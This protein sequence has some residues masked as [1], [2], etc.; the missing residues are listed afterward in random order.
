MASDRIT[1]FFEPKGDKALVKAINSLARAQ[2]R[3][4]TTS[5][6]VT[7]GNMRQ[8]ASA[9]KASKSFNALGGTMSVV[10]SRLLVYAFA[11]A[12]VNKTIGATIRG[13]MKQEDAE[14]KLAVQLGFTSKKL[15]DYASELQKV[16]RFGDEETL[17]VMG[18][19]SAFT[20]NEEQIKLLTQATLDLSEGMGIGLQEA[21]LL[22]G[23][24]FGSTTNSLSRYGIAVKGSVNSTERLESLTAS[25]S[26]KNGGLSE[27]IDTTSKALTQMGNALGDA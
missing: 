20:K 12:L 14:K 10:R 25:I 27:N 1:I 21:G 8:S 2:G 9:K 5:K 7:K 19:I 11:M 26:D 16:T 24:T 18:Q 15:Q 3:L 13:A 17:A 6:K 23:K 4:A 22:V